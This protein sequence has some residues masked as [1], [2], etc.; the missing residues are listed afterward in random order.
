MSQF[1]HIAVRPLSGALGA[2]VSG[3]DLSKPVSDEVFAEILSAFHAHLVL[4]FRA[5]TMTREHLKTFSRRFG[6]LFRQ[7][8]IEAMADD[9]DVVAVLK[10]ADET[11][12]STFGGTWHSDLS[13]LEAPPMGSVLYAVEVPPQGGDTV[14]SNQ[15]LAYETLSDGFKKMLDGLACVQV[16]APHGVAH[17][18]PANLV[19]SRSIRLVRG[20]P[21][22]DRERLH[23][24][25]R[26][27]P[28]TGR[29]AL[30]VNSVY[31]LRF[32]DMSVEE[33]APLL[34]YL[35]NHATRPEFCCRFS[36]GRGDLAV[37]DNRCTQHLAVDDYDGF[38]RLM[39]RTAIAGDRPR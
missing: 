14:W 22:A 5:Q 23:P 4:F 12:I 1:Q 29:K 36:W 15:Y 37:W 21:E 2:E 27:H 34:R 8:N 20:D 17:A 35:F 19:L 7:P 38:R 11:G 28:Q 24:T 31:S 13:Y 6:P 33:S 9:P 30:F 18:P 39:Y 32:E 3:V 26:T 10:E 25:V 16:G